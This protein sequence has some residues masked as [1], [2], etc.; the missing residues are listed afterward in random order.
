LTKSINE[1]QAE[2]LVEDDKQRRTRARFLAKVKKTHNK[3]NRGK[4]A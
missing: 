2:K 1:E 3:Q 4:K